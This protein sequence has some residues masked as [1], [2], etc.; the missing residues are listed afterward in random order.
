MKSPPATEQTPPGKPLIPRFLKQG[1]TA[2]PR[3]GNLTYLTHL[4]PA[5]LALL[6]CLATL[7]G[8]APKS[9]GPTQQPFDAAK[10]LFERTTRTFH[11]PSAEARGAEKAKL[12]NEAADGYEQ[13]LNKYPDQNYWAAQALRSLG[14]IRAAQGKLDEAVKSYAAVEKKYPEQ[15]WEALMAWKSAADALW[16]AGRREDAKLFY[17]QI[18]TQYDTPEAPQVQKII[19][20]GSTMRLAGA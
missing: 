16:E 3:R 18:V 4:T 2:P 9:A 12:Q 11:I 17:R 5:V 8:C 14:N 19:V 10:A 20:Q 13:L 1:R 7:T 15:R 6:L